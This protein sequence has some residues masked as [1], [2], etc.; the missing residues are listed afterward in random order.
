MP[1]RQPSRNP[2]KMQLVIKAL[3]IETH[4]PPNSYLCSTLSYT[5]SADHMDQSSYKRSVCPSLA[6]TDVVTMMRKCMQFRIV[7]T[8]SWSPW[9]ARYR[10]HAKQPTHSIQQAPRLLFDRQPSPKSGGVTLL[11]SLTLTIG[12]NR[13]Q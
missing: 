13:E 10:H 7:A 8:H 5:Q 6:L 12:H 3:P 11:L 2:Q 4:V 9:L 1:R